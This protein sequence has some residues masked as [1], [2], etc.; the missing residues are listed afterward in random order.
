MNNDKFDQ[1]RNMP[2]EHLEMYTLEYAKEAMNCLFDEMDL[3]QVEQVLEFATELQLFGDI[4]PVDEMMKSQNWAEAAENYDHLS[5]VCIT[6][7][8]PEP[9]LLLPPWAVNNWINPD[10][11]AQLKDYVE[12]FES[13]QEENE[14]Y[15]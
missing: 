6:P 3:A 7:K 13:E 5:Y 14:E 15:E 4:K 11:W 10:Q 2:D 8:L 12:L 1:F 9:E